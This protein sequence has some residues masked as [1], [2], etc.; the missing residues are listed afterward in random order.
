MQAQ[1]S[2][3]TKL[4]QQAYKAQQLAS[5]IVEHAQAQCM[6]RTRPSLLL[7]GLMPLLSSLPRAACLPASWLPSHARRH[8]RSR[9][10]SSTSL[11][12]AHLYVLST[13]PLA[14]PLDQFM[15]TS[16]GQQLL[17]PHPFFPDRPRCRLLIC[18]PY[19]PMHHKVASLAHPSPNLA[20]KYVLW[21]TAASPSPLPI[22]PAIP[23]SCKPSCP[24][25]SFPLSA[26]QA[27]PLA[28]SFFLSP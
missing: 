26:S 24:P 2:Q 25:F 3:P 7:H 9:S 18:T 22:V 10:S 28:C 20:H 15:N 1:L 5:L 11:R 16:F 27:S 4:N 13:S 21:S 12:P 8:L 17:H 23:Y 14:R 6:E 19:L